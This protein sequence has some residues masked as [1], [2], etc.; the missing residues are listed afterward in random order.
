MKSIENELVRCYN[1]I[2]SFAGRGA[3]Y[4]TNAEAYEDSLDA[5]NKSFAE[6]LISII[7]K[8][9]AALTYNF[10][11]LVQLNIA[12]SADQKFRIYSWD[13]ETGGTMRRFYNVCAYQSDK[14]YATLI[15]D[16]SDDWDPGLLY[17][18]IY[19]LETDGR[20]VY[21]A[22][23]LAIESSAWIA[24]GVQ[25]FEIKNNTIVNPELFKGDT[26]MESILF[27]EYSLQSVFNSEHSS[28]SE[29]DKLVTC[30]KDGKTIKMKSADDYGN[31]LKKWDVY[32]FN[33]KRFEDV[34]R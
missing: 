9:P 22:K 24:D 31:P 28:S 3:M 25:L 4:D 1:R 12:T 10:P 2:D 20:K 32:R 11:E 15:N 14:L 33:E 16:T 8:Y 23:A 26:G 13:D 6:R 18:R 17:L 21:I 19:T 7:M 34:K 27:S 5:A 30:S 29:E